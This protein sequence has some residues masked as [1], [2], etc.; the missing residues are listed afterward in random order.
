MAL[1]QTIVRDL[2]NSIAG[3]ALRPGERITEAALCRQYNISRTPVREVLK[4]LEK[5][6]LV[7]IIPN[8]G[9]R[10]IDLSSEDVSNIYEMQI[11]LEGASARF[12]CE[13]VTDQEIKKLQECQ[14]MIEKAIAQKN[15]DLVFELNTRF[16]MLLSEFTK[17]P[18]LIEIRKNFATLMSRFGRFA[19]YIPRHLDASLQDHPK[20]IEALTK[21]N[22][23]MAEF[24]ARDHFEKAKEY[25][26]VYVENLGKT[27]EDT[28]TAL[29]HRGKNVGRSKGGKGRNNKTRHKENA[30][31]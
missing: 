11:V 17:N 3:G 21:R 27:D 24:L 12:A 31:E 14:F 23:A 25:M 29:I 4:Q 26:S 5:E 6:G 30:L 7:K 28:R 22:G 20:I 9:A 10:I 16:H 18:Y 13:H 19:T 2:R 8:A 1:K 15:M